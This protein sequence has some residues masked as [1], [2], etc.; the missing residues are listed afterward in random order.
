MASNKL[1]VPPDRWK[2]W[3]E[4]GSWE[5][6][7]YVDEED[8]DPNQIQFP[9]SIC[10]DDDFM[11]EECDQYIPAEGY[12][13]QQTIENCDFDLKEFGFFDVGYFFA[14]LGPFSDYEGQEHAPRM[15]YLIGNRIHQQVYCLAL[16]VDDFSFETFSSES[17]STSSQS[18]QSSLSTET[19]VLQ[20]F[21]SETFS[22]ESLSTQSSSSEINSKT[23][24][25]G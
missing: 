2:L 5:I 10:C 3:S 11:E 19:F 14:G 25:S 24:S 8:V 1:T 17:L 21:S 23:V 15:A 7:D 6:D 22:T 18:S 12:W 16:D 4:I 9:F 13:I 20:T